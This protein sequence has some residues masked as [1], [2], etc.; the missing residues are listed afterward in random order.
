MPVA[1]AREAPVFDSTQA[2]ALD[3]YFDEL[4]ELFSLCN[5]T[6]DQLKKKHACTYL[7]PTDVMVFKAPPEY[8]DIGSSYDIW[9]AAIWK[10]YPGASAEHFCTLSDVK[11]LIEGT[12]RTLR[13][14]HDLGTFYRQFIAQTNWLIAKGRL[15][16]LEQGRLFLQA[17]PADLQSQV[18]T[19][20]AAKFPD[21]IAD[22]PYDINELYQSAT[23]RTYGTS[24]AYSILA[25]LALMPSSTSQGGNLSANP[26]NPIIKREE[27]ANPLDALTQTITNA[28]RNLSTQQGSQGPPNP[29]QQNSAANTFRPP[30]CV[31]CKDPSHYVRFCPE[32]ERISAEGKCRRDNS[33][34]I[35]LNTG[36]AVPNDIPGDCLREK[37]LEWHRRNPGQ[38]S[39]AQLMVSLTEVEPEETPPVE[40]FA[41]SRTDRIACLQDEL[42]QL[43]HPETFAYTRGARAR[44]DQEPALYDPKARAQPARASYQS[45][46]EPR[47]NPLPVS[48]PVSSPPIPSQNQQAPEVSRDPPIHPYERARDAIYNPPANHP[49]AQQEYPKPAEREPAFRKAV[50]IHNDKVAED[51][52]KRF[53]KGKV[54]LSQEELLSVAPEVRD[55]IRSA[56]SP[57]RVQPTGNIV[58][59]MLEEAP[60]PFADEEILPPRPRVVDSLFVVTSRGRGHDVPAGATIIEDK[61]ETFLKQFPEYP[62]EELVVAKESLS[63]RTVRPLVNHSMEIEAIIDPG[64]QIIAMSQKI[65]HALGLIYDP[66]ITLNMQSA[67]GEIDKSLGLA[68]NVPFTFGDLTLYVQVHIIKS[69]A[70]DILL[71]RPFDVL[72]SS[73]VTNYPNEDQTLTLT[74]PN[75]NAMV[76]VPTLSRERRKFVETKLCTVEDLSSPPW[77]TPSASSEA[78][79]SLSGFRASMN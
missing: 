57:K 60:L 24:S 7:K 54:E 3:Q 73:I 51:I 22:D 62:Q 72:T 75:T 27:P 47:V 63:L 4:E 43:Q 8:A 1:R 15:S 78:A 26:Y 12:Q 21:H 38:A 49:A 70:Y 14:Q 77:C 31:F 76:T 34:R 5:V 9:K 28:F 16:A 45:P 6:D 52:F 29:N 13:T 37:I 50:P 2:L 65:C 23:T 35:V 41:L 55:K 18:I 40:A 66:S 74:D 10:L 67:N 46:S 68:R 61:Y 20:Q 25:P 19:H 44:G 30:N 64:C 39:R 32:V 48:P 42:Y 53:L 71:G 69:P 11:Q 33:G 79:T 36:I 56:I 59:A 58:A 17:L